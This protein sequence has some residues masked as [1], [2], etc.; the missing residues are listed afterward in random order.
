M[1]TNKDLD[2]KVDV[3]YC[4]SWGYI[5]KYQFIENCIKY[6]YPKAIVNGESTELV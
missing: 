6:L 4:S 2:F 5:Y 1:N 3:S